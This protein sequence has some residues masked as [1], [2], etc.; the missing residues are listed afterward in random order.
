MDSD[1]AEKCKYAKVWA[2]RIGKAIKEGTQL[3]P[4]PELSEMGNGDGRT[5]RPQ[6][7]RQGIAFNSADL[8]HRNRHCAQSP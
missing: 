2:A 6:A 1:I 4:P 3:L 5:R 7:C 8:S